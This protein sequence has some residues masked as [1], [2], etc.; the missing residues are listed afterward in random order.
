MKN[1]GHALNLQS[2]AFNA[3]KTDF[4]SLLKKTIYTMEQKEGEVAKIS[5]TF[6][7]S[8]TK[9]MAPDPQITAYAA[10]REVIIPKIEH[11]LKS[12]IQIQDERSGVLGGEKYEMVWDKK[13]GEYVIREIKDGP[14]LFDY[15]NDDDEDEDFDEDEQEHV[16]EDGIQETD[17]CAAEADGTCKIVENCGVCCRD[18]DDPQ[19][20]LN[21]CEQYEHRANAI[22]VDSTPELSAPAETEGSIE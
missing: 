21:I 17:K 5:A 15:M 11:K 7:I 14:T 12:L 2:D 13:L 8:L 18:C 16:A 9:D 19:N 6:K 3:F 22:D 1:K 10:E 20:C 4:N